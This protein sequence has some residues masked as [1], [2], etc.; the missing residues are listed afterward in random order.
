VLERVEGGK[1]QVSVCAG[2]PAVLGWATGNL[3]EPRNNPQVGMAN[4]R[5]IMPAL[6]KAKA[7]S[8]KPTACATSPSACPSSSAPPAWSKTPDQ[9]AAELVASGLEP[10][11]GN[12]SCTHPCRRNRLRSHQASLEAVTAG[13]ELAARLSPLTHRHRRRRRRRAASAWPPPER[14]CWPSPARPSPSRATPPTPP[15][16]K[17]SAAPRNA[18]IVLAPGSSRFTRVAAG[19]AHRLGGF[20]DTHITALGGAETV[21]ATRWFYRQ[22]IEAV[23]SRDARPW[24]LLLDAGTHAAF[25][26]ESGTRATVEQVAVELPALRTTVSGFRAPKQDAADHPPRRQDALRR[27]RRLD[28]EAARRP[29]SRPPKPA[30]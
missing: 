22:R 21:E 27:R 4:M 5:T 11:N 19:V 25:A 16:A 9:I 29:D 14:A 26:G 1:H 18:T 12:D 20:I 13:K 23:L 8:S 7:A 30:S 17:P 28:Q 24:F 2:T 15:P 6:Q 3:A 10:N